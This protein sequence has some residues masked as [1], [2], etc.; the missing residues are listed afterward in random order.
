MS[1]QAVTMRHIILR[2]SATLR[3][4]LNLPAASIVGAMVREIFDESAY[5]RFLA[6]RK[7]GESQQSYAEFLRENE[8][9]QSRRPR[10]C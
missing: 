10:C 5:A 9:T 2:L 1:T 6:R 7:L 8:M 4:V 3:A